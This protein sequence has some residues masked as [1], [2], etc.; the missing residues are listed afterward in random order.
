[1]AL[2]QSMD[3]SY[4]RLQNDNLVTTSSNFRLRLPTF[5]TATDFPAQ[6]LHPFIFSPIH[7]IRLAKSTLLHL[8][9]L[10]ISI[11]LISTVLRS[12]GLRAST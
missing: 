6:H 8:I 9:T 1:M 10:R 2:E 7:A 12:V 4:E 11:K 3:L 5:P